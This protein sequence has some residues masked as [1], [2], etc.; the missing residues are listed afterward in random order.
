MNIRPANENA[1][2]KAGIHVAEVGAEATFEN[3]QHTNDIALAPGGTVKDVLESKS[4]A[5]EIQLAKVLS[6]LR[7]GPQ[8]TIQ[9]R[10]AGIM[11]PA[12]RIHH[13]RHVDGHQISCELLTLHDANGFRH[14]KCARYHLDA[15]A[16]AKGEQ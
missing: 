3:V 10:D 14:S 6:L 15:E 1:R 11:M 13:L 9:L 5:T 4:T 8:T 2:G 7:I 16:P 12:S